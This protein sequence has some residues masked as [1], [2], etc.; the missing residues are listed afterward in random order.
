M[1]VKEVTQWHDNMTV[2]EQAGLYYHYWT[3][4]AE[5]YREL[6]EKYNRLYDL[7]VEEK[8]LND[9]AQIIKIDAIKLQSERDRDFYREMLQDLQ[10]Y[11][12][13]E[14]LIEYFRENNDIEI[15]NKLEDF[16]NKWKKDKG[17]S[18]E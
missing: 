8:E 7:R 2:E 15:A 6:E 5:S 17:D 12:E 4:L 9:N 16:I 14:E 10:N 11:V 13:K 18:N 1:K 3:K